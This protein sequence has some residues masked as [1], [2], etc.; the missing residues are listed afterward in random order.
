MW[1]WIRLQKV[2]NTRLPEVESLHSS[3]SFCIMP[4]VHLHVTQHGTVSPCCQAPWQAEQSFGHID[5]DSIEV[6][7]NNEKI[8]RFRQSMLVGKRDSR[9]AR[10]YEKEASGWTS[11]RQITNERFTEHFSKVQKTAKDGSIA[12]QPVYFDLRFSNVC[13]FKCRICGPWSSSKWHRD[14]VALGMKSEDAPAIHSCSA[15]PDALFAQFEAFIEGVEEMYFAG[16]EPLVMEEHYRILE[17]LI[18]HKKFD[19]RLFYNTNFSMLDYKDYDLLALW[20]NFKHINLAVSLDASGARGEYLRSEQNWA[21]TVSNRQRIQRELPQVEFM[22]SPTVY[23]LNVLHLPDFHKEWVESGLI[24]PEEF[25]PTLLMQPEEYNIRVLPAGLKTMVREKITAHLA[26]LETQK[27]QV[28]HPQK[29][30]HA[31]A[32]FRN[33]LTHLDAGDHS[34]LW[35][36]LMER[37][38]ALDALRGENF[39]ELFEEFQGFM[40]E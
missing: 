4:W 1:N 30:A 35:P 36:K 18:K 34:E 16:G 11:L 27:E 3:S 38:K 15:K 14:G 32:Q 37:T 31:Q 39:A 9:C 2:K 23:A 25:I 33:I 5:L 20:K 19:T 28:R 12:D 22:V 29:F 13:N 17:L 10:C 26:W 21:Q 7:W 6:L 40:Q 8:R 24:R